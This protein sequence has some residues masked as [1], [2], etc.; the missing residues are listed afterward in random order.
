MSIHDLSVLGD[1]LLI[2]VATTIGG[3]LARGLMRAMWLRPSRRR[4]TRVSLSTA[5]ILAVVVAGSAMWPAA[6][7]DDAPA[8]QGLNE[9]GTSTDETS[10]PVIAFP[11]PSSPDEGGVAGSHH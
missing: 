2:A 10:R 4:T 8:A 3:L 7:D 11:A 6:V 9:T 1:A 5:A